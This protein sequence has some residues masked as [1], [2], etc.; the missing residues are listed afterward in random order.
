MFE[1]KDW[2]ALAGVLATLT[3]ALVNLFVNRQEFKD[4]TLR[5]RGIKENQPLEEWKGRE[6][7]LYFPEELVKNV[8]VV[9]AKVGY[10][11]LS[12]VK[13]MCLRT[14]LKYPVRSNISWPMRPFRMMLILRMT[15]REFFL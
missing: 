8:P 13:T 12:L 2:I 5:I 11:S 3:I 4:I 14:S 7:R 15:L 6:P 1:P 9:P 10:F